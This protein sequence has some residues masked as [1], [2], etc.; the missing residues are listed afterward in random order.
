MGIWRVSGGTGLQNLAVNFERA[1]GG[2]SCTNL[3][4]AAQSLT[5]HSQIFDANVRWQF[6]GYRTPPMRLAQPGF[7][8]QFLDWHSPTA[9]WKLGAL[10]SPARLAV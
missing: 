8:A 3:S 2:P 7:A 4:R 6:K 10:R 9:A 5:W 1:A